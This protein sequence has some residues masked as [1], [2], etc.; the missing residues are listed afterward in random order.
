MGAFNMQTPSQ[1]LK[2]EEQGAGH[3]LQMKGVVQNKSGQDEQMG[4]SGRKK[5]LELGQW[6]IFC[7]QQ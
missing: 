1:V 6:F 4:R 3:R 2:A 5:G 7:P